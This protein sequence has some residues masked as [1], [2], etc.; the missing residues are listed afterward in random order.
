M[1]RLHVAGEPPK[2]ILGLFEKAKASGNL[3]DR[4]GLEGKGRLL[5]VGDWLVRESTL[6]NKPDPAEQARL[7]AQT[8]AAM[9]AGDPFDKGRLDAVVAEV[10]Y[11]GG[12]ARTVD[13]FRKEAADRV[14]RLGMS[15]RGELTLSVDPSRFSDD[16]FR[17]AAIS[18]R[19]ALVA[20]LD[21]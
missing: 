14:I 18:I 2:D 21:V 11:G 7:M 8:S 20:A 3:T 1:S 5:V 13:F 6:I 17:T 19:A 10:T 16:E 15:R 4:S 9:R 12:E